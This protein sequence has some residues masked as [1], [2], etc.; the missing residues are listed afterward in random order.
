MKTSLKCRFQALFNAIQIQMTELLNAA[1]T[2][3][4]APLNTLHKCIVKKTFIL[5]LE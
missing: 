2:N 5:S 1:L 3:C 4:K